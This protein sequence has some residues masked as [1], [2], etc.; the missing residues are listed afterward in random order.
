MQ[1]SL[2]SQPI[3]SSCESPHHLK[4]LFCPSI[5]LLWIWDESNTALLAMIGSGLVPTACLKS[6]QKARFDRI[7]CKSPWLGF[8]FRRNSGRN[9]GFRGTSGHFDRN[10]DFRFDR[11][12]GLSF[13]PRDMKHDPTRSRSVKKGCFRPISR[14]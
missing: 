10:L 14:S 13:S 12:F 2:A 8:I 11:N 5:M 3:M 6:Q 4:C 7:L 9:S 1:I